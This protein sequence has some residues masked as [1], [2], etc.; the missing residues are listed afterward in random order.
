MELQDVN[1]VSEKAGRLIGALYL[2]VIVVGVFA[3]A[4]IRRES[5]CQAMRRPPRATWSPTPSFIAWDCSRVC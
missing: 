4:F 1:L 3:E 5:L 2:I